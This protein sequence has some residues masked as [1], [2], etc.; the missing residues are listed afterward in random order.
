MKCHLNYGP[1]I[2]LG[3]VLISASISIG[4]IYAIAQIRF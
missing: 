2:G 3:L 1:L 4:I